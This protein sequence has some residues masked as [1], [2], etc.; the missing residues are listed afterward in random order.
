MLSLC[1]DLGN[2]LVA[3]IIFQFYFNINIGFVKFSVY[4]RNVVM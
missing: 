1:K 2:K 3:I 4:L